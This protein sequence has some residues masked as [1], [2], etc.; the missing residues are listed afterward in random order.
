MEFTITSGGGLPVTSISSIAPT[1]I[2]VRS[3]NSFEGPVTIIGELPFL[4]AVAVEGNLPTNGAGGIEYG[5]GNG[6][7]AMLS[8]GPLSASFGPG[9]YAQG[10]NMAFGVGGGFN[11]GSALGLGNSFGPSAGFG[12]AGFANANRVG[13][14]CGRGLVY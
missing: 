1:G 13:C 4:S 10:P 2:T 6:I 11:S 12:A 7:V 8:E 14:R 5:C 9:S 3:D